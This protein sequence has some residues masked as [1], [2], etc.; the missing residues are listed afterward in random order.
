MLK[1]AALYPL[2]HAPSPSTPKC[3]WSHLV[4][5]QPPFLTLQV[6]RD[7]LLIGHRQA[8]AWVDE[9]Y[10]MI[11]DDVQEYEKNMH[12]QTNIKVW[13]QHSSTV[14]DRESHAQ[15]ST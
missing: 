1:Q 9:W 14:D 13:S 10:D 2:S 15:T 4:L 8:F 3:S 12:E 6:V 5:S 11:M 7:I